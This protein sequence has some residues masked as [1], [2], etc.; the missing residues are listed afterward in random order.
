MR[1]YYEESVQYQQEAYGMPRKYQGD[2]LPEWKKKQ[3]RDSIAKAKAILEER[4]KNG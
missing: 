1:I 2:L 4:K 3:I